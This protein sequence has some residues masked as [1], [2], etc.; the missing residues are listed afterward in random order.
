MRRFGSVCAALLF[1]ELL[2]GSYPA[3]ALEPSLG[4]GTEIRTLERGRSIER[5][6]AGNDLPQSYR[7]ALGAGGFL[8][9]EVQQLGIDVVVAV[10]G[11]DGAKVAEV[12]EEGPQGIERVAVPAKTPGTYR[13]EVR[14]FD[15]KAAAGRYVVRVLELLSP[16]EY[17]QRLATERAQA[18]AATRWLAGNAIRLTTVEAGHGFEDLQPLKPVIGGARLVAFGEAT[19]GTREFFQLKHRMLEF[20]VT[21]MGFNVFGIEATMPEAFDIN[22]YV[23]TGKGDPV[24]ALAALNFWTWDTEEVLAMIEWMRSYNA[25]AR[26]TRKVK[27]YGFDMQFAPRAVQVVVNYLRQVDPEQAAA[28]EKALTSLDNPGAGSPFGKLEKE[29]Q[30][31]VR[32]AAAALLARFDARKEAYVRQTGADDW[33]LARQHA[34]IVVQNLDLQMDA[35]PGVR[36]RAMADNVRWILE[37]EGPNARMVVWAH[38]GHVATHPNWMGDHLRQ[39]LGRQMVVFGFAFNQG[40]FQAVRR[41]RGLTRF[42]VGPAREGSL[43][44]ALAAAGLSLA[45]IDLRQLPAKGPVA[46]WFRAPHASRNIGAIFDDTIPDSG[47]SEQVVTRLYDALLFVNTTTAAR[48]LPDR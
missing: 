48:E 32:E 42:Q 23:L 37:R 39:K 14:P 46:E 7:V 40:G 6:L 10:Y 11:P 41:R 12:D 21:E 22:E 30:R 33:A 13:L 5:K 3:A 26:H 2:L 29:K 31:E 28:A 47:Y 35:D 24:K 15:T 43:D 45:M 17:A 9:V 27:F 44:A 1:G 18:A 25:D 34:R 16:S 4:Q 8:R 36:D 38:N 19:H 20:L